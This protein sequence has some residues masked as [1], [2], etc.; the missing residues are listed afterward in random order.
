VNGHDRIQVV[1]LA[2]Q[3]SFRLDAL[4]FLAKLLEL[5]PQFALDRFPFACQ[6][7]ISVD[8]RQA[9]G[10]PVVLF[11]LLAQALSDRQSFLGSVLVLPKSGLG[12]LLLEGIELSAA[13]GGVKENS[14][15][16][17]L[18]VSRCHTIFAVRRSR[19]LLIWL[20]LPPLLT[21]RGTACRPLVSRVGQALPLRVFKAARNL[22][23]LPSHQTPR[24]G[25]GRD[26]SLR[27]E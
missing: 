15:V 12:N 13:L 1:I 10:K 22:A 14:A 7:E 6:L 2:S 16:P 5:G 20:P 27:S 24:E 3:E 19:L 4:E 21:C 17:W 11:D 8:V 23:L 18:V 26:S 9:L 25:S